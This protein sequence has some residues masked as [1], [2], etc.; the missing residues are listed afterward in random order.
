FRV[1]QDAASLKRGGIVNLERRPLDFRVHQDAASLKRQHSR[2]TAVGRSTF[3]RSSGR[4]LIEGHGGVR[5][6]GAVAL[7]TR[8]SGR[9]LNEARSV[10]SRT[11]S[12]SWI[13][14]LIRGRPHWGGCFLGCS[15]PTLP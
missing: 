4:R 11:R 3:P 15:P 1:H 6:R 14:P 10:W 2:W 5:G 13:S 12:G 8:S 9:G 7:F